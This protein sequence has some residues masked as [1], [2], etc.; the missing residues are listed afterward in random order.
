MT[1]EQLRQLNNRTAPRRHPDDL[2]H[3]LQCACVNW[4]NIQF[5]SRR[6]LLFAVPN[7]GRRDA[8]TGAKLKAE[9]VVSGVSDLIL[10]EPNGLFTSLCI[11]MKTPVGRQSTSQRTWQRLV[12]HHCAKYVVCR[13]LAEFIREIND[14]LK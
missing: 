14:Y 9:G 11:E 10:L 4:F 2:E 5:P 1:L 6:G 8:V 7:G 3:R 13:S 12:E